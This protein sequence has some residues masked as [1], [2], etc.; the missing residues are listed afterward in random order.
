VTPFDIAYNAVVPWKRDPRDPFPQEDPTWR[1]RADD[2][3]II[4]TDVA[5]DD[6][7][8]PSTQWSAT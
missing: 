7:M 1:Q 2:A 5:L 6:G 8:P 3:G 4:G